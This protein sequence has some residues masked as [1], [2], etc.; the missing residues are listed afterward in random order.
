M[1]EQVDQRGHRVDLPGHQ[2][3]EGGRTRS[4]RATEREERGQW[5][6]FAVNGNPWYPIGMRAMNVTR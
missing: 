3:A 4:I 5:K 1:E 6:G 2:E